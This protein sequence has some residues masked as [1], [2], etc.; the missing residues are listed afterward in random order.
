[1]ATRTDLDA[2]R[3]FL[4]ERY[5]HDIT[6]LTPL[7]QGVWSSA[8]AFETEGVTLVV[9][10]GAYRDDF[11]KDGLAAR[12][13]SRDLP[14]PRIVE[15]GETR[16]GS[17]AISERALGTHIDGLDEQG[18]RRVLLSLFAAL[19]AARRV[20]LTDASGFGLWHGTGR[21]RHATW[22]DA[23]LDI[24]T[25][26]PT[27][28]GPSWR[29]ALARSPVGTG[30]FDEAFA[31]LQRLVDRCP[32]GRHLVHS[33]LLHFN[34]LVADD[35]VTAVLDWG[36]SI[37]GDFL[38]DLAW[39]TFWSPWYPAWSRIDFAREAASYYRSIG[40]E[41]PHFDERLH[42]YELHIGMES[43][44]WFAGQGDT[45]N[46]ERTATRMLERA[47]RDR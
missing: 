37:Y 26:G 19:E 9:R 14:I 28:L 3:G 12:Y 34:V 33:D 43:Q 11:E 13:A 8:Y 4:T 18:M 7:R 44:G 10:F 35:R 25:D 21:A 41:V 39:L 1:L 40:L 45:A 20:D 36:S 38:Y 47:R 30:P 46:L 6:D 16:G 42:C 29:A 32:E 17:Y 23:L 22:H 24:A 5:G 27:R 31:A 2:A 15:I